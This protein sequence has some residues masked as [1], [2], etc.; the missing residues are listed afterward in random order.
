M[1]PPTLDDVSPERAERATRSLVAHGS[2]VVD[3]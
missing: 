2:G 1:A 3:A